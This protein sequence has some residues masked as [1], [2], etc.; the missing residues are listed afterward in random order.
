MN[1]ID[2]ITQRITEEIDREIADIQAQAREQADAIT[3]E[4]A[5]RA[6]KSS[7]DILAHGQAA[8]EERQ[9][10]LTGMA[11]MEAKKTLLAA[12]QEMISR[13]FDLALEK[14]C[15]LPEEEY[16]KLL[17][18]LAVRASSTGAEAVIFSQEDR[19]RIGKAVVTA[20]NEM[21]GDKGRLTLATQT[22]P[23]AGGL[24][25]SD[26]AVEINCSFETLVRLQ[27]TAAAGEVA[28]I[29]FG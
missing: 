14:L 7:A 29:L 2:K 9:E 17:A 19:S 18:D 21:L 12:K 15:S 4:Y 28:N 13:A 22:R 16:I 23:M 24:I 20:A 11:R 1:G 5:A 27:K 25:L 26:G 8:A 3:A 6:E 10:R